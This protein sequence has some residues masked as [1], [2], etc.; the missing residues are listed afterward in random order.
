MF[1]PVK[2][3]MP[4]K[5]RLAV[6]ILKKAELF[7]PNFQKKNS[8]GGPKDHHYVKKISFIATEQHKTR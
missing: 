8:P 6:E 4:A 1:L 2:S 7:S 5:I 3:G